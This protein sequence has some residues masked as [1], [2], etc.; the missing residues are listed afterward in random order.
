VKRTVSWAVLLAAGLWISDWLLLRIRIAADH[1]AYGQIQ[2]HS[3]IAVHMKNKRIE[4]YP[5]TARM[6]ECVHSL[7]PHVDDSPCWYVQ[8]HANEAELLDGRGWHFWYD[9]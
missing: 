9:E 5:E 4:Q 7:F 1:N 3:S 2:V 6:V 8:R